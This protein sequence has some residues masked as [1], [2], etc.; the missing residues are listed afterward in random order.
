[1]SCVGWAPNGDTFLAAVSSIP[2][3]GIGF[4]YWDFRHQLRAGHY[5]SA[6]FAAAGLIPGLNAVKGGINT[7]RRATPGLLDAM[8]RHGRTI[9]FAREG[10]DELRY[11]NAMGAEA[12]VGGSDMTHILLR[13]NPS[14]AAALEEFLHGTQYRLGIVE[15]LGVPGAELHVE[16]FMAR[17]AK[18]LGLK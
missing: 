16:S 13:E 6:A 18:L 8:R 14:M 12:N 17:H 11:L 1:M 4:A 5:G 2:V 3:I 15:R 10:S 9:E 7:V